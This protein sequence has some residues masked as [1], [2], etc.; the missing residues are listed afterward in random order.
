MDTKQT[1]P[2][3]G[4][5]GL[6]SFMNMPLGMGM[7]SGINMPSGLSSPSSHSLPSTNTSPS[8]GMDSTFHGPSEMAIKA[9]DAMM[10]VS[11]EAISDRNAAIER[12]EKAEK[13]NIEAASAQAEVNALRIA[14]EASKLEAQH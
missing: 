5:G 3:I 13:A 14:L 11:K 6:P 2:D 8:L 12:A 7:F 10:M 4:T 1:F 9:T